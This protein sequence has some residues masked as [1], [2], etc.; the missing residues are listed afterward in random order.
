MITTGRLYRRHAFKI[1]IIIACIYSGAMQILASTPPSS[2]TRTLGGVFEHTWSWSI[3]VSGVFALAGVLIRNRYA[4]F[5]L[6]LGGM[7]GLGSMTMI[8]GIAVLVSSPSDPMTSF[9]GPITVAISLACWIRAWEIAAVIHQATLDSD[10]EVSPRAL[11]ETLV[12]MVEENAR[13][14]A[15]ARDNDEE[16]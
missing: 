7:L 14:V 4:G 12:G 2:I 8:Y 15:E 6:E 10:E 9:A 11:R 3:L 16:T 5:A 1:I 13:A